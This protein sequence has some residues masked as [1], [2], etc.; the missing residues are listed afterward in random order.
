MSIPERVRTLVE[1]LV[2]DAGLHL[3][4]LELNGGVLRVVVEPL[5]RPDDERADDDPP[6]DGSDG[7]G[8]DAITPLTRAISRAIDEHDPIDGHFTLEVSSPGLERTLRTPAHF[9]GAVGQVV[10]IKTTPAAGGDRRFR[11]LLREADADGIAVVAD[12]APDEPRRLAY[13]DIERARTVFEWGPT[14]KPGGGSTRTKR[15]SGSKTPKSTKQST[16]KVNAS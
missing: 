4:D 13:G 6:G 15:T 12:V 10:A 9:Q 3:Y 14:P 8:M 7:V 5:V 2:D 11:G 1:P 16:K